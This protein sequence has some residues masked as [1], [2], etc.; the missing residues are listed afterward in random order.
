MA[1]DPHQPFSLDSVVQ[2]NSDGIVPFAR[3][4][5]GPLPNRVE[6]GVADIVG[7]H[8]AIW[9]R[10]EVDPIGGTVDFPMGVALVDFGD[11]YISSLAV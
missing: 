6:G 11:L 4:L 1:N 10:E 3:I 7:F 9:P 5:L 8:C 2:R